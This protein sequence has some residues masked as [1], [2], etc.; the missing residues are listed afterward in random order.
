[1]H[2]KPSTLTPFS[3]LL[4]C[5]LIKAFLMIL[6][7]LHG[8]I[9]LGSDEAQYWTW[10][11]ALDWGY[12]SKP[13]G[14][15]WQIW[16]GT[17]GFGSTE[18]G[19]RVIAVGISMAQALA[20]YGLAIRCGLSAKVA[21]HCGL[22]MALCPI[23]ILGSLL[24]TTDGGWLLFWTCACIIVASALH[25]KQDA[26]PLLIGL[27]LL[28]GALFKWTIYVFWIFF[29]IAR[30]RYFPGQPWRKFLAGLALSLLGLLPSVWWNGWHDWATF[31][32]VTS[33]L[34]GGS[35]HVAGSN[36]GAFI[37]AQ[38]ALIS[39]ILFILLILAFYTWFKQFKTLDPSLV[40]CGF[41]SLSTLGFMA[42]ASLFQKIQGNWAVWAYP[43]AIILLGW[44][45]KQAGQK[46]LNVFMLGLGSSVILTAFVL[47]IP[48]I[49]ENGSSSFAWLPH[50]LN[51]FKHNMGWMALKDQLTQHGYDPEKDFLFS[52][53]YQTTSLLSFYSEGQKRA[54]FLNLH[55]IRKNQ[56]SYWPSLQEEQQEKTGYFIWAENAPYLQKQW[57]EKMQFYENELQKYFESVEFVGISP[58]LYQGPE[59]VKGA[60][61]FRCRNC[62][63]RQ[64]EEVHLY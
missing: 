20:V 43:T 24:A 25:K 9:S 54:Y 60:F 22:A 18:L 35:E 45:V 30:W 57:K 38:A 13:P 64:P 8:G 2:S 7:I 23:G 42:G 62:K 44:F 31:R 59:I 29:L 55:G 39:P 32:H 56:F 58:L 51:P 47:F 21:L 26:D 27:C 49:Q 28:A 52:D 50:R 61:I 37:G 48:A 63:N 6:F 10:S 11:Q 46:R 53:K 19:V 36:F 33:T 34:Q 3:F 5:L 40:F 14:I 4:I 1:M 15:A 17:L 41:V 12:Y 16:L